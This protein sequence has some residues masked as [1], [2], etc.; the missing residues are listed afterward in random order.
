M[1]QYIIK[2]NLFAIRDR[3]AIKDS[4]GIAR[5]QCHGSLIR[6]AQSFWLETPSGAPLFKARRRLVT[7]LPKFDIYDAQEE[8]IASLSVK[9]SAFTKKISVESE[10]YGNFYIK[11]GIAAWDFTI[12]SGD[13]ES[14]PVYA[15]ISKKIFNVRDAY[16]VEI[17]S[18]KESFIM[19]LCII[20]DALYHKAK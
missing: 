11:G 5:F 19:T 13:D 7:F 12:Y 8:K 18:G 15:Q 16:S 4:E 14:G 17:Y 2:Q 20:I 9:I 10:R 1:G 3:F 6:I